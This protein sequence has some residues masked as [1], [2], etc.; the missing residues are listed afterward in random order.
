MYPLRGATCVVILHID[1]EL[2]EGLDLLRSNI[3]RQRKLEEK[4][5]NR[6]N[7]V[8]T[9]FRVGILAELILFIIRTIIWVHPFCENR[10]AVH[11]NTDTV[12]M[13]LTLI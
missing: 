10:T 12:Y 11:G 3:E 9:G 8:L 4:R 7:N 1:V 13:I 6:T 2:F 5:L